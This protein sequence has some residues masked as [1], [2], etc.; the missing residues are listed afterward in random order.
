MAQLPSDRAGPFVAA[1]LHDRDLI[2]AFEGV[3]D[4]AGEAYNHPPAVDRLGSAEPLTEQD[5]ATV[6]AYLRTLFDLL[7]RVAPPGTCLD[8]RLGDDGPSFGFW[9]PLQTECP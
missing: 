8:L 4:L 6:V 7:E 1:S 5:R 9:P 2:A 3:L